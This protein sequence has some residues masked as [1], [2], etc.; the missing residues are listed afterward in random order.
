MLPRRDRYAPHGWVAENDYP[1][2][3]GAENHYFAFVAI[4]ERVA[5][6]SPY[7]HAS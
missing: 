1:L 3:A 6:S 7:F 4:V 5:F 2:R